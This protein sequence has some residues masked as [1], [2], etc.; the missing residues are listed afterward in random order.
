MRNTLERGALAGVVGGLALV[1]VVIALASSNVLVV[2]DGLTAPRS[3]T[4]TD[5]GGLLIA[6]VGAGRILEWSPGRGLEVIADGIPFTLASG[7]SANYPSGPSA[8]VEE[9]GQYFY[10][11]GEH[12]VPGFSELYRLE[13]GG[14]PHPVTGQE[15]VNRFPTNR[16]TNPYDLV[17]TGEGGFLV[18]D[19]GINEVLFV[20]KR[21]EISDCVVFPRQHNPQ[22]LNGF[23]EI[24]VVPTGMTVGPD[25]AVYLA[26]LT[27]FPHPRGE[28]R[29][30]RIE[31]AAGGECEPAEFARGFTAATDVAFD[32]DGSL[33]VTEF[34]TDLG[35][36]ITDLD[37]RQAHRIPGRLVRW[38]DGEITVVADRLVSPTAVAVSGGRIFVSE[39]FA[40]RISEV[41]RDERGLGRWRW[42]PAAVA[43]A[44]LAVLTYVWAG[45][46]RSAAHDSSIPDQ[47]ALGGQ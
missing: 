28:A 43:G 31:V 15:I 14:A 6:E 7:P 30:F 22:P 8:V 10:V 1:T 18:S 39:E 19:A 35:A 44:V 40:G 2:V 25:G 23:S 13:P 21:G 42:L 33:L 3:L 9:S 46:N 24:D 17:A 26:S 20:S 47:H 11:V 32:Q 27:G 38:E 34:S 16:L 36:L 5:E 41:A 45:R 29:V 37:V 12:F 4:P